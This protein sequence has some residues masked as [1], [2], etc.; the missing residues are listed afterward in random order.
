[1]SEAETTRRA[2]I[3][4][5]LEQHEKRADCQALVTSLDAGLSMARDLLYGRL[6]FDVEEMVGTDSM[7]MPLSEPK[8][9][10]AAKVQI[11]IFQ[12]VESTDI[13]GQQAYV[14]SADWY[15]DWLT[16][17]RLGE[18]ATNEKIVKE[19]IAYRAMAAEE[20][21]MA[22]SDVLMRVLPESHKAPLVLFKL[23]PLAIQITTAVA[24]R[25][26]ATADQLRRQQKTILP[27]IGDCPACRGRVLDNGE[28][29]E[30]CSNPLWAYRWLTVTD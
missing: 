29:C 1:M 4:N 14:S 22:F 18:M 25:D 30:V 23:I 6:H 7:L 15:L 26:S 21:R 5:A 17:F 2:K 11:E 12:I 3:V 13:A 20:R 19:I 28:V 8:T 10:R 24:F 16:Q 27:A 9:Q